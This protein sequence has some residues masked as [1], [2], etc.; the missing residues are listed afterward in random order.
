VAGEAGLVIMVIGAVTVVKQKVS[1]AGAVEGIPVNTY[2]KCADS[3]AIL[4]ARVCI[5]FSM[6]RSVQ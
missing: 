1:T 6:K 5:T 3:A 2:D 4:I